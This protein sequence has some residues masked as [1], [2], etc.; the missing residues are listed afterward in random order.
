[1]QSILNLQFDEPRCEVLFSN[2]SSDVQAC[3]GS[4]KTTLLVAKLGILAKKW[5][6]PHRGICVLSHTNVAR[7]EIEKKLGGI[8]CGQK[9]LHYPH[10][11]G[12]IHGFVNEFLALPILRSQRKSDR[13]IIDDVISGE[14]C[15]RILYNNRRY[16]IVKNFLARKERYTP[17]KTITNLR[18]EGKDL[19][20]GSAGA[21][22][23]CSP[24]TDSH[25]ML[26][27]IKK[28]ATDAGF[29]RYDDMFAWAERLLEYF[30]DSLKY[31][32]WRFPVVLIDEAQDTSELQ[33]CLLNKVFP[34]SE[35]EIR[36]RYGDS[37]QAIYDSGQ[38]AATTDRFPSAHF[39]T[40]PN[41]KRFGQGIASMASSLAVDPVN[42]CL[43]GEGPRKKLVHTNSSSSLRH[44]IYIFD[45]ASIKYVLPAFGRLLLFSFPDEIL[46]RDDFVARI[47]GRI[48][49]PSDSASHF[50]SHLGDYFEF[51]EP[52]FT[53]LEPRPE[54]LIGYFSIAQEQRK[55]RSEFADPIST[56]LK[57]VCEL[58]E[59]I[60]LNGISSGKITQRQLWEALQKNQASVVS[61]RDLL[62][63][64]CIEKKFVGE[65]NWP[66][67]VTKL[68]LILEPVIGTEWNDDAES[69]CQWFKESNMGKGDG[70]SGQTASQN[71]FHFQMNRR[72]VNIDVGT[73]H[74]AKGQT[75]TATLV[76]ETFFK[77]HDLE[78]LLPWICG[79]KI[80]L[81]D[82]EGKERRERMRLIY[83]AMTRPS[84]L[85]CL[86]MRKEAFLQFNQNTDAKDKLSKL[87]W[88]L[89]DLTISR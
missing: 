21:V 86:A 77:R 85:L 2:A 70:S 58:V 26:E 16:I 55:E 48:G 52:R 81:T 79:Y 63:N 33:A 35:C 10:F 5:T 59:L 60:H 45:Q 64:L 61:L 36:Q 30:P 3:P 19:N 37:N 67:I 39:Q 66:K 24:S 13:I 71:L 50:P 12:T 72:Q 17:D 82:D 87:G 32:R 7:R 41:S 43:L 31:I 89:E 56:A 20:L 84:H 42:P 83:T 14:F 38:L 46:Q 18:F 15:R 25:H 49:K 78:D 34:V 57:G 76:V 65:K 28:K 51:Y 47:I 9:L 1:M 27:E 6:F 62:W 44:T 53:R 68:R 74:S 23:P 80:G 54:H 29:W 73:I 69:F 88:T 11:V 4:G 8:S 22:L 75:H 40:I